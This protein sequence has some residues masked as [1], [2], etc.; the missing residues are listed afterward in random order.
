MEN[1]KKGPYLVIT[2]KPIHKTRWFDIK[3]D[4]VI[5]PDGSEASLTTV[6]YMPGVSVVALD[7]NNNIFLIREYYYVL[8]EYGI[9]TPTGGI[10]EGETPLDA[11]KKELMEEAGIGAKNWIELGII[12][13]FTMQIKSPTHLFLAM[14]I[15]ERDEVGQE[16][17]IIH[18]PLTEA[19]KMV[20]ENKI[21]H[22]PSSL[23]ILKA[24]AYL[25][26]QKGG[27]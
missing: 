4:Q 3:E 5:T 18:V 13:P 9:Q 27:V 25:E 23:A 11:A 21:V 6:D 22:A 20:L 19:I 1:V 15:N 24:A 26:R 10:E 2:S 14:D 17:D 7:L 8:D 12:H 16:T